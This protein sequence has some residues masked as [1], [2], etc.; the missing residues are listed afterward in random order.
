L[1]ERHIIGSWAGLRPLVAPA[2]GVSES[3]TSREHAITEGET[4][5]LTISGGKLTSSRLMAEQLVNEVERKLGRRVTASRTKTTPIAGAPG[6]QPAP[7]HGGVPDR[8]W[9]RWTRRY[10]SHAADVLSRWNADPANR[11]VIGARELTRAELLYLVEEE[12]A[13]TLA[14]VLVRRTSTFFWDRTGGL[15]HVDAVADELAALLGWDAR[16]KAAEI[17]SYARLVARH[18]P[19][20]LPEAQPYLRG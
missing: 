18:R 19:Y 16:R 17:E 8:L 15:S 12:M 2:P 10:G 13:C 14:D 4:G 20:E 9:S 1:S 6:A 7:R 11:E 3:N 5:M